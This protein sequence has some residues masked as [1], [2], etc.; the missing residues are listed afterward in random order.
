MNQLLSVFAQ[1][2]IIYYPLNGGQLLTTLY[3]I[4]TF[5]KYIEANNSNHRIS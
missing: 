4:H 1:N 3:N 2:T 5:M